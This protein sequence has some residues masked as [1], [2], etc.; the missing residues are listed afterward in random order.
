MVGRTALTVQE[1]VGGEAAPEVEHEPRLAAGHLERFFDQDDRLGGADAEAHV[2]GRALAEAG[3]A[4][5]LGV[6]GAAGRHLHGVV[7]SLPFQSR[8]P[9]PGA[10]GQPHAGD[11]PLAGG[12]LLPEGNPGP[13]VGQHDA[14]LPFLHPDVRMLAGR[15]VT[16][17]EPAQL[18]RLQ[19]GLESDD[20]CPVL[21][22]ELVGEDG[23]AGTDERG[24]GLRT[25]QL[26]L[27]Q[28]EGDTF[29][30]PPP[31]EEVLDL[32]T[33]LARQRAGGAQEDGPDQAVHEIPGR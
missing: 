18:E 5:G 25:A 19:V 12:E 23:P 16:E 30:T 33:V 13:A 28:R 9:R 14:V 17:T 29:V 11:R 8:V 31:A 20:R 26:G 22:A 6:D 21:G 24:A 1:R 2:P 15:P 7:G 4:D 27:A 32:E 3:A 10:G